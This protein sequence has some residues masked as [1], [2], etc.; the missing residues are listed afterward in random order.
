MY[1]SGLASPTYGLVSIG[2]STGGSSGL[3]GSSSFSLFDMIAIPNPYLLSHRA[4]KQHIPRIRRLPSVQ[5]S[6]KDERCKA[7]RI[8]R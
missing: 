2:G 5:L 3:F 7:Y 4:V 6:D 8:C 1:V